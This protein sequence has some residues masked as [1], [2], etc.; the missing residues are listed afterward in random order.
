MN[1][2]SP[3]PSPWVQAALLA[4]VCALAV[5]VGI[6]VMHRAGVAPALLRLQGLFL[7]VSLLLI[8]VGAALPRRGARPGLLLA[9]CLALAAS[10]YLP[11]LLGGGAQARWLAIGAFRLHL[12]P[13]VLPPLLILLGGLVDH[14]GPRGALTAVCVLALAAAALALQPDPAQLLAL[15]LAAPALWLQGPRPARPARI[16]GWAVGALAVSVFLGLNALSWQYV[17]ALAP[18]P[19]VEGILQMAAAQ[20]VLMLGAALLAIVAVLA[21]LA[22]A[23]RSGAVAAAVY[24]L[25]LYALAPLQVTPVPLLGFGAGPLLGFGAMAL[26]ILAADSPAAGRRRAG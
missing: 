7:A 26:A 21:A 19:H 12:A 18:V 23:R 15:T 1:L 11:W 22:L 20:G 10:L 24:F 9:I 6:A 16:P 25:A 14:A 13:V 2:A 17:D 5:G 3:Q 4:L 8:A